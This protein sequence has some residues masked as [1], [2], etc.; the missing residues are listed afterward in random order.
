[1]IGSLTM[2]RTTPKQPTTDQ[3]NQ[4]KCW[5]ATSGHLWM[6]DYFDTLPPAVRQRLRR[7]PYNLCPAC[8]VTEFLPK[9]RS[10]S[11]R[12]VGGRAREKAMF[13]A[14]EAMEQEV[15]RVKK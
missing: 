7:S 11:S 9:I 14:I 1:M 10:P 8:M 15:R 4:T 5:I 13:T 2:K 12:P 3:E 6:E